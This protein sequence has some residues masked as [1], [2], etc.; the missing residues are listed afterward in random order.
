MSGL[1]RPDGQPRRRPL[2]IISEQN[3]DGVS[4]AKLRAQWEMA[5]RRGRSQAV[6]VE[7]DGWRDSA[8]RLWEPNWLVPVDLPALKAT[9]Q[10]MIIGDATYIRDERGTRAELLLMPPDAFTV[11]PSPLYPFNQQL[12]DELNAAP[13]SAR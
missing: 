10:D 5:R 3:Y 13:R 4:L 8:G 1:T 9:G 6:R 2:A 7:C 12:Q 11:E